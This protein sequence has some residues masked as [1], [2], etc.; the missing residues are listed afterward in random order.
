MELSTDERAKI[1]SAIVRNSASLLE[2]AIILS[3]NGRHSR[4]MALSIFSIEEIGKVLEMSFQ[5][6]SELRGTKH[7]KRHIFAMT[8]LSQRV[9]ERC[10]LGFSLTDGVVDEIKTEMTK[11]RYVEQILD[12]KS[13]LLQEL[14]ESVVASAAISKEKIPEIIREL[15]FVSHVMNKAVGKGVEADRQK[16]LY[17]D[18]QG[19]AITNDPEDIAADDSNFWLELADWL[20]R[21]ATAE[22][23]D[24]PSKREAAQILSDLV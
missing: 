15:E 7:H 22:T 12:L 11:I 23:E 17:L 3:K 4:S 6:H 21:T 16:C 1:A 14:C 20:Y 24:L 10:G 19:S 5:G 13:N 2:D 18:Y 9:L 8:W